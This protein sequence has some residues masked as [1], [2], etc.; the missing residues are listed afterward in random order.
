[1]KAG[2]IN[3]SKPLGPL[4]SD[5]II[6]GLRF[7]LSY[8]FSWIYVLLNLFE[9]FK[10]ENTSSFRARENFSERPSVFCNSTSFFRSGTKRLNY[11]QSS[12]PLPFDN[13]FVIRS[14]TTW[15]NIVSFPSLQLCVRFYHRAFYSPSLNIFLLLSSFQVSSHYFSPMLP[16]PVFH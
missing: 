8:V 15:T 4:F 11:L 7:Q 10:T 2:Y 14:E 13:Y 16:Y 12:V 5:A 6:Q 9:F 1:M 3:A